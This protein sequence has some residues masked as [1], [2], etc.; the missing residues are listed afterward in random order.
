MSSRNVKVFLLSVLLLAIIFSLKFGHT[1]S[2]IKKIQEDSIRYEAEAIANAMIAFR[3]TYQNIFIGNHITIDKDSI[4]FLPTK[5]TNDIAKIL[6]KKHNEI[7]IR[8]VTDTPKNPLN[9]VNSK[10][11][12]IMQYFRDNPKNKSYFNKENDGTYSYAYPLYIKDACLKCHGSREVAPD[13]I[14]KHY[15]SAYDYKLGDLRGIISIEITQ[16]K[17]AKSIDS[18]ISKKFGLSMALFISVIVILYL[19][20]K[21]KYKNENKFVINSKLSKIILI[22]IFVLL[23]G[24]IVLVVNW[25]KD[26]GVQESLERITQTHNKAYETAYQEK[27]DLSDIFFISMAR[28]G[29]VTERLSK[30][31]IDNKDRLREEV[32]SD[33]KKRYNYLKTL[34]VKQIHIHLSNNESFLRMHKPDKYGDDL[35]F[36]RP[37]VAYVNKHQLMIDGV[38]EGRI[39]YGLRF[40]YPL[41]KNGI[42]LGSMEI[43]FGAEAISKRLMK[44]HDV[45][46]NFFIKSSVS[47][48]KNFK[49][50]ES[51]YISSYYKGYYLDKR[52]LEELRKVS[53][54]GVLDLKPSIE[55]QNKIKMMAKKETSSSVY[56]EYSGDIFTIIPILNVIKKENIAFLSIRSHSES[57]SI[58]TKYT[59]VIMVLLIGVLGLLLYLINILINQKAKL[60]SKISLAMDEN[61][62]QFQLLQ[63]QSKMAQMGEMLGS[64]AH[65][66]RQPLNTVSTSIQNL[67]YDYKENLLSD[68]KYVKSFIDENKKTIKFMSQTIDDFRNFFR[69]DKEKNDFDIK[70]ATK[71]VIDMQSAQLKEHKIKLTFTADTFIFYGLEGEYQQV[72]L[73]IISNAKDVLVENKIINPTIEII[74]ED[75]MVIIKDNAGGIPTE[76]LERIFE[77]Y[78]TTKEQGK[79]TGIGL[80]MSKMLIEDGM[81]GS[82]SVKNSEDGAIFCI[83]FRVLER[84]EYI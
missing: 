16:S 3:E 20:A 48:A 37:S 14:K 38:E 28:L 59:L 82:L 31:N 30:L 22:I 71:S 58:V 77:P 29:K 72:I 57:F 6:S 75:Y 62:R 52:V 46:S 43:S 68:E 2:E 32:Y 56:D 15:D 73:N 44:N 80:Y 67:K 45:L 84:G 79:G 4:Y 66:W 81:G 60:E 47:D 76:I 39:Y 11:M 74:V 83:D 26:I 17:L 78:F 7:K 65:Q 33:L 27:K 64:I 54:K 13:Y 61:I 69:V 70:E 41:S 5:T 63:Q 49:L 23:S 1:Y 8:T 53:E 18:T 34:G 42:H 55:M 19:F 12:K 40:V 24:V 35:T 36:V 10:E 50:E 21:D 51:T 9:K 25:Y